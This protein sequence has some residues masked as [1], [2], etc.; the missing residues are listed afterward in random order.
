MN[1][2][3]EMVCPCG[4]VVK[5]QVTEVQP[6]V[7]RQASVENPT[8]VYFKDRHI[9]NRRKAYLIAASASNAATTS[10][11]QQQHRVLAVPIVKE[12]SLRD[13]LKEG[14]L[15]GL[16]TDPILDTLRSIKIKS[17]LLEPV[18]EL[19]RR[20]LL[21]ALQ[22]TPQTTIR[23]E[24]AQGMVWTLLKRLYNPVIIQGQE[25]LPSNLLLRE[26]IPDE[27]ILLSHYVNNESNAETLI[28]RYLRSLPVLLATTTPT[29][30]PV[31]SSLPLEEK[32]KEEVESSPLPESPAQF[33]FTF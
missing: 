21:A 23:Y 5:G 29:P 6:F 27:Q 4:R 25:I 26:A 20:H 30:P 28:G 13:Q 17:E 9:M 7:R 8:N 2:A 12:K 22:Y 14:K 31:P 33:Y 1:S 18:A 10:T 16:R 24:Q 19:I 15:Q 11:S 32:V 3:C